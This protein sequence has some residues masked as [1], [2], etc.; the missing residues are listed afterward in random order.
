MA[1]YANDV[2]PIPPD[3]GADDC[4]DQLPLIS[5]VGRGL[6]GDSYRIRIVDPDTTNETYLEGGYIDEGDKTFHSEWISENIN[7]GELTY[8]YNLNPNS[9][10]R[11]FT[12]T[13]IYKRPGRREWSWTTPSIPYVWTK[14][15]DDVTDEDPDHIIGSGV[16]TIY[17]KTMHDGDWDI[18]RDER[19]H[20]PINPITGLVH[21]R[22]DF[23]PPNPEKGWSSTIVFGYNGDVDVPDFDDLAKFIGVTKQDIYDILDNKQVVIE[24]VV[25]DDIIDYIDRRFD[26]LNFD[27]DINN[28]IVSVNKRIG[29]FNNQTGR[30]WLDQF[31]GKD[32]GEADMTY[33]YSEELRL[34]QIRI[35][36]RYNGTDAI[37]LPFGMGMENNVTI[38]TLPDKIRPTR[39]IRQQID[40]PAGGNQTLWVFIEPTGEVKL[41]GTHSFASTDALI[42]LKNSIAAANVGVMSDAD[43]YK[44]QMAPQ[45]WNCTSVLS[46]FYSMKG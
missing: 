3:H 1:F 29:A 33:G 14:D 10:P 36:Y 31:N 2:H 34:C 25:C 23:N 17:C 46:Y 9:I 41:H 28:R 19:L 13:F 15:P 44:S 8:Q 35:D 37:P 45:A 11:T 12:I 39:Q 20:Y 18:D 30:S 42:S 16:A 26:L 24:G 7:G 38:G 32:C 6:K 27:F 5:R 4:D 43:I 22:K 40:V 21:D